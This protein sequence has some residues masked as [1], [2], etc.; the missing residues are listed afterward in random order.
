ML[1]STSTRERRDRGVY[2]I[3][4]LAEDQLLIV[5]SSARRRSLQSQGWHSGPLLV[6]GSSLLAQLPP[7]AHQRF[8]FNK[9]T[10]E[11]SCSSKTLTQLH[12]A[13]EEAEAWSNR[14]RVEKKHRTS[15]SCQCQCQCSASSSKTKCKIPSSPCQNQVYLAC[16]MS[17]T[18]PSQSAQR[19]LGTHDAVIDT[20]AREFEARHPK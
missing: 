2:L 19:A 13:P 17:S 18:L 9:S 15:T 7:T 5:N 1:Q 4:C 20:A 12:Q 10:N 6:E 14:K 3:R 16:T 11:I 8:N